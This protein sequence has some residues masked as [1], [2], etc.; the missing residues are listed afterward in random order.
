MQIRFCHLSGPAGTTHILPASW[1]VVEQ[2]I[3]GGHV[4]QKLQLWPIEMNGCA[5]PIFVVVIV[6]GGRPAESEFT[7]SLKVPL[8]ESGFPME[9]A[10]KL[11]IQLG[12][13]LECGK[14]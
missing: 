11:E 12:R 5:D 8:P 6:G 4:P 2:A 3:K 7:R 14:K 1:S 10:C 9:P 13:L